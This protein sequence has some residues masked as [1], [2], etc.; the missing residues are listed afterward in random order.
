MKNF[1]PVE[2]LDLIL[3]IFSSQKELITFEELDKT[4]NTEKYGHYVPKT[5]F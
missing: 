2:K 3:S 4:I 5:S 1:T